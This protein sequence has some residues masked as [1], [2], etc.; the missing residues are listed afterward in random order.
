MTVTLGFEIGLTL[1]LP[2][3]SAFVAPSPTGIETCT[4]TGD[5]GGATG[6]VAITQMQDIIDST[7]NQLL[8]AGALPPLTL[9]DGQFTVDLWCTPPGV[10]YAVVVILNGRPPRSY[11]FSLPSTLAPGPVDLLALVNPY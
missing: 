6:V 9:V 1:G 3:F 10:L 8:P 2:T 5:F 7:S 4:V 11:T